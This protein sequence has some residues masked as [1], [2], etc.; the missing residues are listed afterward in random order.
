MKRPRRKRVCVICSR[1]FFP[2]YLLSQKRLSKR[3]TC[4]EECAHQLNV[5]VRKYW[6]DL[7]LQILRDIAESLPPRLLVQTF[8]CVAAKHNRPPRTRNAIYLKCNDLNLSVKPLYNTLTTDRIIDALGID[9]NIMQKW[10]RKGL[11][12]S[13]YSKKQ[14][15]RHYISI[16]DLRK[17]ARQHPHEFGG[18]DSTE[19]F[20]LIEDQELVDQIKENYPQRIK[21]AGPMRVRCIET[22]QVFPSQAQAAKHF[23]L[24]R[25]S[26]Y[27]AIKYKKAVA[28]Y[29]FEPVD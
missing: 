29:H 11:K 24:Y 10:I 6:S 9:D 4:S 23:H 13:R 5:N 1:K 15:S 22:G 20:F 2:P 26:L 3:T 17:F 21:L 7:D 18:V 14:R 16:S 8:N 19:L 27:K 25:S 28:G 12:T